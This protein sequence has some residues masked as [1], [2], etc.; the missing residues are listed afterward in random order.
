MFFPELVSWKSIM[1]IRNPLLSIPL[2]Y[3]LLQS[4]TRLVIRQFLTNH[5]NFK[6][7][8]LIAGEGYIFTDVS[9]STWEQDILYRPVTLPPS[10]TPSRGG[11]CHGRY[12]FYWNTFLFIRCFCFQRLYAY[13][14]RYYYTFIIYVGDGSDPQQ[15]HVFFTLYFCLSCVRHIYF[16]Q[17]FVYSMY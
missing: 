6:C 4:L 11:H 9:L 8:W 15:A 5:Q 2:E 10:P 3:L 13:V 7:F 12:A 14:F 1:E 16:G 17:W